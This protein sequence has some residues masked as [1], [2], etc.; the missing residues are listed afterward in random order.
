MLFRSV[1][2]SRYIPA[3]YTLNNLNI[4]I[5]KGT[6]YYIGFGGSGVTLN[7]TST[8]TLNSYPEQWIIDNHLIATVVGP[9]SSLGYPYSTPYIFNWK[10]NTVSIDAK[11]CGRFPV[12][13]KEICNQCEKPSSLK[14]NTLNDTV[15]CEKTAL[16]LNAL[17]ALNQNPL[18]KYYYS[19]YKDGSLISQS[20]TYSDFQITATSTTDN[21][22]YTL[23]IEDGNNNDSK[24]YLE[25]STDV[26]INPIPNI[27][28]G[29]DQT[30]CQPNS[31]TFDAGTG[32]DTTL[33]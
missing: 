33:S 24:C 16:N 3:V 2:Q 8:G 15:M 21:G 10:F 32:I 18:D 30:I 31:Y 20:T 1:S 5:P 14:F 28:L 29:A 22:T 6:G 9:N 11:T 23:R 12:V 4:S 19:W 17:Y 25:K 13:I 7:W 26:V 27:D